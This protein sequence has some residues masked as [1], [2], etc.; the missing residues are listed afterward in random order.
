MRR[1]M[2]LL[3][4]LLVLC[5]VF[6]A[7]SE[8]AADN[9]EVLRSS[10]ESQYGVTI[11]MGDEITYLSSD[12]YD[13]RIISENN[14]ALPVTSTGKD[15]FAALLRLMERALSAY[16]HDFF[17]HFVVPH[18][19]N[20][21]RFRLVDEVLKGGTGIGGYQSN[22]NGHYDI[23]LAR[24]IADERTIHHIIWHAME[25]R[26]SDEDQRAFIGWADLNPD[27][28]WYNGDTSLIDKGNEYG[29]SEAWFVRELSEIN[30][31]EDM[32]TVFEAFMTKDE[33][34]WAVRPHL[35]KKRDFLLERIKPYFGDLYVRDRG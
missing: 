20:K 7:E 9:A 22:M 31:R 24:S 30:P 16:P 3:L 12:H 33:D 29:E 35:Q 32:A 6:P 14:A 25:K 13:I 18:Y 4:S 1:V 11:Q 27:D 34:W 8:P 5:S 19:R 23:I 26:I 15:R 28:F 2:T 17:S 10:L 21:L